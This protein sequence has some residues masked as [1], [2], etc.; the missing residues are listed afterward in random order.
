MCKNEPEPS[1]GSTRQ[2][3]T[4]TSD[5]D[6]ISEHCFNTILSLIPVSAHFVRRLT[7]MIQPIY[8]FPLLFNSPVF[9][10]FLMCSFTSCCHLASSH[11][12]SSVP[13]TSPSF[14]LYSSAHLQRSSVFTALLFS[15]TLISSLLH[16]LLRQQIQLFIFCSILSYCL[17]ALLPSFPY[18]FC[19][20]LATV[21]RAAVLNS[22]S[23]VLRSGSIVPPLITP[24]PPPPS[25]CCQPYNTFIF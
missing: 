1:G 12:H 17:P 6:I 18:N 4:I 21:S 24:P 25:A 9:Q 15:S 16:V 8:D 20:V 3:V 23:T 22:L 14:H 5:Y 2:H 19:S 11:H 13:S 10:T 7:E